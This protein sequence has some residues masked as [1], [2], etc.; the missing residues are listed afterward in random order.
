M[1][2][3]YH[4]SIYNNIQSHLDERTDLLVKYYW[5]II[6]ILSVFLI[7]LFVD[8]FFNMHYAAKTY[9]KVT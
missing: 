3:K 2:Q 8:F 7:Y 5:I 1:F 6:A 9:K 4:I